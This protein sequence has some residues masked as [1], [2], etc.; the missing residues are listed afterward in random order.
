MDI[1][2]S[3]LQ[4]CALDPFTSVKHDLSYIIECYRLNNP[5]LDTTKFVSQHGQYGD[6][7]QLFRIICNIFPELLKSDE[8]IDL[9]D[10]MPYIDEYLE[11]YS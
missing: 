8:Y 5:Q 3:C 11:F 1:L 9:L 6:S 2:T 7:Q 10:I 4:N